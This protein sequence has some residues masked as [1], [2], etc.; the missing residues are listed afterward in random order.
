MRDSEVCD[1][2]DND[3]VSPLL[4]FLSLMTNSVVGDANNVAYL[5]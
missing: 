3:G 4:E 5:L 2:T 1:G